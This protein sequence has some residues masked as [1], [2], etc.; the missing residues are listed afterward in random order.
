MTEQS[1]SWEHL[2]TAAL[3]SGETFFGH[4][5][6]ASAA[7]A[8]STA[9]EALDDAARA[10]YAPLAAQLFSRRGHARFI[11]RELPAAAADY[12]QAIACDPALAEAYAYHGLISYQTGRAIEAVADF[13]I[14]I[15]LYSRAATAPTL[16]AETLFNRGNA[17]YQ[18]R[19]YHA[20]ESDYSAA[21]ALDPQLADALIYRGVARF[22]R[23]DYPGA[24]DDYAR[25]LE[26]PA[27]A[28]AQRAAISY[29]QGMLLRQ[30]GNLLG[31]I[32]AYDA[33]LAIQPNDADCLMNRGNARAERGDLAG[34]L[35]DYTAALRLNPWIEDGFNIRGM[36]RME[37]GAPEDAIADFDRAIA[38]APQALHLHFNRACARLQCGD[39]A[40]AIADFSAELERRA[41]G[42]KGRA[43]TRERRAEIYNNRGLAYHYSGNLDA[44]IEDYTRAVQQLRLSGG[45]DAFG[46]RLASTLLNRGAALHERA[47]SQLVPSMD[48][49]H[50]AADDLAQAIELSTDPALVHAARQQLADVQGGVL[51]E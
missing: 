30:Q 43:E 24:A 7:E 22:Q 6:H 31:A 45:T 14:A 38:H 44:A 51:T 15:A 48:D 35:D 23:G 49:L 41:P 13:S 32:A 10:A 12:R 4:G 28:P 2:A 36:A 26:F 40:G 8:Y 19:D 16:L 50:A 27:L 34:A 11:R 5:D 46:E 33:A 42:L 21:L 37:S 9:L 1:M 18:R 29:N 39:F 20:A 25:A 47:R 3:A 17:Q